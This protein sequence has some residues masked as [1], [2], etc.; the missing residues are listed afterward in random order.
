MSRFEL[1]EIGADAPSLVR[2]RM[3]ARPKLLP[4]RIT[5]A[6]ALRS[7]SRSSECNVVEEWAKRLPN[8]EERESFDGLPKRG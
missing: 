8:D 7:H 4:V 2:S 6:I 3:V 1:L 5:T